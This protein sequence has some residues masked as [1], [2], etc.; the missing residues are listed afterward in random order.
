MVQ[1]FSLSDKDRSRV[2]RCRGE[3]NRIGFALQL[4]HV[5]WKGR[6]AT[7]FE[8]VPMFVVKHISQRLE[9]PSPPVMWVYPD[10]RQTR[11]DHNQAICKY[12]GLRTWATEDADLLREELMHQVEEGLPQAE[13]LVAAETA[14]RERKIVLP[15]QSVIREVARSVATRIEDI[16][17]ATISKRLDDR[18]IRYMESLL[19]IPKGQRQ[20]PLQALKAAP[21]RASPKNLVWL[22]ERVEGIKG[23]GVGGIDFSGVSSDRVADLADRVRS[24]SRDHLA[25]FRAAKRRAFL[26]CFLSETLKT[27]VDA[28]VRTFEKL[29]I[30]MQGRVKDAI[31]D[32]ALDFKGAARQELRTWVVAGGLLGP[33]RA[34]LTIGAGVHAQLS[35]EEI[36]ASVKRSEELIQDDS[37]IRIEKLVATY[38]Y[39]RKFMPALLEA[40]DFLP[41]AGFE[42]L[43]AAVD[44]VR[45]ANRERRRKLP[46]EVPHSPCVVPRSWLPFV[47]NEYG[48]VNKGAYEVC[49]TL[50]LREALGS[51]EIFVRGSR[52][53]VSIA[54]LLYPDDEWES[55]RAREYERFGLPEDPDEFL[56]ALTQQLA[57]AARATDEGFPENSFASIRRGRLK[58]AKEPA[59]EKDPEVEKLREQLSARMPAVRIEQLLHDVDETT[60]FTD[61]FQPPPATSGACHAGSSESPSWPAS[62][63][64]GPTSVSSPW[65]AWLAA[66][67]TPSLPTLPSGT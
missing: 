8:S 39:T 62:W 61:I 28:A 29:V 12:L 50:S 17:V 41:G 54:S 7:S 33:A 66:S 53:Y 58:L 46:D 36:A 35:A 9:Y 21:K 49:L 57:R 60:G 20:S 24:Y 42:D 11:F 2:R 16:A 23:A 5:R 13:M 30:K 32:E 44:V 22:C 14:L 37:A 4:C 65:G 38:R 18:V 51:G 52:K 10:R 56:A 31:K 67:R 26:A 55:R 34:G 19:V 63:L 1:H 25:R 27:S 43:I 45:T 47:F 3:Q 15:G 59:M 40:V 6:F 64:S 48:E